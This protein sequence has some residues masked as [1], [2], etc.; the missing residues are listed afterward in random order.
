MASINNIVDGFE[1]DD[2]DI[3]VYHRTYE[4]DGREF[5]ADICENHAKIDCFNKFIKKS[6]RLIPL[7]ALAIFGIGFV[8]RILTL[9]T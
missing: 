2:S 4:Y 8:T 5:E 3:K 6:V 9:L 1:C 7:V